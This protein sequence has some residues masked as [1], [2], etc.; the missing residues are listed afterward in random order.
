M[1]RT[2]SV[3]PYCSRG[4]MKLASVFLA[5]IVSCMC[6]FALAG[7]AS[8]A[9]ENIDS[10]IQEAAEASFGVGSGFA[11]YA[12]NDYVNPSEYSVTSV[13]V[14][15]KKANGSAVSGTAAI[16]L[17]NDSFKSEGT[18]TFTANADDEGNLSDTEFSL[19]DQTTTVKRGIDF[20][21]ERGVSERDISNV[22]TAQ[23]TCSASVPDTSGSSWMKSSGTDIVYTYAFDGE[24]WAYE[25]EDTAQGEVL[26]TITGT[27]EGTYCG[28]TTTF[29]IPIYPEDSGSEA[30]IK[31][32]KYKRPNKVFREA[33]Y[34]DSW[35]GVSSSTV[36]Q[37]T[38]TDE[39]I[40]Y[41]SDFGGGYMGFD[42]YYNDLKRSGSIAVGDIINFKAVMSPD[43]PG[44]IRL[45]AYGDPLDHTYSCEAASSATWTNG[46]LKRCYTE[47]LPVWSS[48]NPDQCWNSNTKFVLKRVEQ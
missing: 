11:G 41:L 8:K 33:G 7:C 47:V 14:Q 34:S 12:A 19:Q 38:G 4:R 43:A 13:Q 35:Y 6:L 29:E 37:N 25:S 20:D 16:T 2:Q 3:A 15:D 30:V 36:T 10:K 1:E 27:Y 17:E 21:E 46:K 28:D 23:G 18:Y 22:N 39:P 48:S 24:K 32:Y 45:F 26:W 42:F 9:L 40:L 31:D 5:A 44:E